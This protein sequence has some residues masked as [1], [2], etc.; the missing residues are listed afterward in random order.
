MAINEDKLHDF[1][2][3]MVSDMGAS[4]SMGLTYVGEQLGLFRE[5][6]DAG[7]M[8]PDDLADKTGFNLRLLTEWMKSQAT[9][10][11]LEYNADEGTF[12]LPEEQAFVLTNE[13]SPVYML[14]LIHI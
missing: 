2:I 13:S 14:S 9:G 11:Y 4:A 6:A 12:I 8:P 5:M 3:S 1:L 7:P 10:G